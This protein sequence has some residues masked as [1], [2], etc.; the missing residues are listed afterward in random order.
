MF[1]EYQPK[2]KSYVDTDRHPSDWP[3]V[4]TERDRRILEHIHVHDGLL[5][6]Y[7][8]KEL[9]FTGMR[10]TR[11][12]LGKLF[13]NGYLARTNRMGRARYGYKIYWLTKKGA[14]EVAGSQGKE[15]G[16]LRYLKTPRWSQVE[17]D[18]R[19]NDFT[20][21]IQ[22]ACQ[23]SDEEFQL[24]EW[25]NEGTFRAYPDTVDYT[26]VTNRKARKRVI[27]DGYFLVERLGASPFRSRLLLELDHATH[28]NP[29]FADEKVLP[30][31]AYLRSGAYKQRFGSA[32]GRWLV[33]TTG[34]QRL[35]YLKETTERVAGNDAAVWYF[36]TFN[37]VS[38]EA[39]LTA[40]IWYP[41]GKSEPI[42]LFP[43]R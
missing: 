26:S 42:P 19:A 25:I 12:R 6:D 15:L 29:R 9:E 4:F 37:L 32:S 8:V 24:L 14:Q 38:A 18:V 16:E 39:V 43:S 36:T 34:E 3:M 13:H 1:P 40:P 10:Q 17:H 35:H 33:V 11:E 2:T 28:S 20:I 7:Q 5:S 22:Q 23:R 30:G 27:P 41:G 31:V 21:I